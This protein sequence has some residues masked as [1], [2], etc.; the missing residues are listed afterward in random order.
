MMH[1]MQQFR[2]KFIKYEWRST[3]CVE[4]I[5]SCGDE[6]PDYQGT[7]RFWPRDGWGAGRGYAPPRWWLIK[8][9]GA[10]LG[11]GLACQSPATATEKRVKAMDSAYL[12][13]NKSLTI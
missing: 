10:C 5:V 2:E 12:I 11:L 9:C 8:V 13:E 7:S 1:V 4:Q 3:L 6:Y